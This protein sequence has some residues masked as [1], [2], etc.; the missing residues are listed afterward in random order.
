MSSS[1]SGVPASPSAAATHTG[2]V[3]GTASSQSPSTRP[4]V[5][6]AGRYSYTLT[7]N[8]KPANAELTVTAAHGG[9]DEESWSSSSGAQQ[10]GNTEYLSWG[11]SGVYITEVSGGSG[12]SYDC[13]LNPPALLVQ[14]PIAAG[15]SWNVD[16]SCTFNGGSLKWT[17]SNRVLGTEIR[18]VGGNAVGCWV[19]QSS[20]VI[21]FTTVTGSFTITNN[22]KNWMAPSLGLEVRSES[23]T[24]SNSSGGQ[25]SSSSAVLQLDSIHPG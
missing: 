14:V 9:A 19:I 18:Q 24:S 3:S 1:A 17:G 10:G 8:G 21:T 16:S 5:P 13:K 4:T 23:T 11:A 6:A 2:A 15:E 20:L 7:S 22:G 12:A 25:Q